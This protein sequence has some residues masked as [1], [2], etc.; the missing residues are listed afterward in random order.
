MELIFE[1]SKSGRSAGSVPASDVPAINIES[2]IDKK[3][4]RTGL[5]LPE[6]AEG[7]RIRAFKIKPALHQQI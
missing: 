3:Y 7:F 4:L 1:K 2:V 6:V 5:D